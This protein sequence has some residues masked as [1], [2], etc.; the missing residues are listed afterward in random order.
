MQSLYSFMLMK[1]KILEL[2]REIHKNP[3][4]AFN[5]FNTSKL[6]SSFLKELGLNPRCNIAG[7]GVV[8]DICG[9]EDGRTILLRADMDA[10]PIHE[11][12]GLPYA[13]QNEGVMHACGHDFHI[14][15]LLWCA[16]LLVNDRDNFNGTVRLLF[17]PAEEGEGGAQPMINEGVMENPTVDGAFAYH[18]SNEIPLGNVMIKMGGFMASPDHFFI[19]ING[20]GGHGARPELCNNPVDAGAYIV[21]ALKEIKCDEPFVIS[22]GGFTAG[23]CENIIPDNALLKGT[24]RTLD[25]DT[26]MYIYEEIKKVLKSAEDKFKVKTQLDYHFLYPPLVNDNTMT[27][28]FIKTASEVLGKDKVVIQQKAD[29][30]GEDFAYFINEVPGCMAK[31]GGANAPLHS[32]DFTADEDAIFVGGNLMAQFA[33]EFLKS[34]M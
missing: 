7:T 32:A 14:A 24:S 9:K 15:T 34:D 23:T 22:I 3:E 13:S 11:Q 17:Q 33:K 28:L 8:A 27:E 16:Y 21:S 6:I 30:I 31:L 12:T 20:K 29:M 5:E 18:I 1:N 4:M 10:L 19:H 25:K 2:R 26:R